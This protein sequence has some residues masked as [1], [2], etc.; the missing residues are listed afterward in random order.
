MSIVVRSMVNYA[1]T[2][3]SVSLGP[4]ATQI[5]NRV[6]SALSAA[7][8]SKLIQIDQVE[9]GPV[10]I[11]TEVPATGNTVQVDD[12]AEC[13]VL[14]HAGTLAALTVNMPANP[15]DGQPL[16]MFFNA[17]VTALTMA[18]GG[19]KTLKAGL[20]AGT[21]NGFAKWR[22]SKADTTWYRVG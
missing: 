22:Y 11:Q 13:L 5:R 17:A 14:N 12:N 18:A 21:A 7:L 2:L 3:D 1:Q 10:T 16:E 9:S 6:T 15:Y 8:A 4:W 19:T 20:T